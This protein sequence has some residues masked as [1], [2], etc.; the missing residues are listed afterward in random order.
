MF[1]GPY[2]DEFYLALHD[3]MHLEVHGRESAALR[4]AWSRVVQLRQQ[5]RHSQIERRSKKPEAVR[6]S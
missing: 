4:E 3:A 2:S 1:R 5:G 6:K